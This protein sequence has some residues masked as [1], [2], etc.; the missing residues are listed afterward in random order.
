MYFIKGK[1]DPYKNKNA[2]KQKQEE[3]VNDDVNSHH[4]TRAWFL[5]SEFV[6]RGG[7]RRCPLAKQPNPCRRVQERLLHACVEAAKFLFNFRYKH[8][9]VVYLCNV[10]GHNYQYESAS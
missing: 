3:E 6:G 9:Y 8:E 4:I 7:C 2:S 1:E 5:G 10:A